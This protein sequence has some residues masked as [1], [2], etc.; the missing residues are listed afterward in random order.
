MRTR[1]PPCPVEK[2]WV[3]KHK[4]D[5]A[6]RLHYEREAMLAAA[7]PEEC[8][9]VE[10]VNGVCND[11]SVESEFKGDL[12]RARNGKKQ[13]KRKRSPKPKNV[14][15]KLDSI[16]TGLLADHVW[17]D[18]PLY[19]HAENVYRK[20]IVDCQSQ[21][22]PE[23]AVTAEQSP[24]VARSKAV[25]D[26]P[27]PRMLSAA[28]P[29]FHGSLSAC[30]HVVQDVWVNK[31]DFDKAEEVFVE[32]SQFFVPPNVLTIPSAWSNAGN[33][34]LRTPDEG[35]ATALPTPATPSL[36]PETV[37]DSAA[38][39]VTSLPGSVH[40]T[41]NGKPQI[42][43]LQA[44][45][46]EV[47]LEKPLYDDAEKSFYENMFDGHPSG[48]V[49]QQQRGCPEALKN[50]HEDRKNHSVGKQTA[51]KQ[52]EIATDSL[53]PSD[54]EQPLPTRFFLHEDSETVWLNKPTY[55]SAES[56]Y[57]AAE[58]LKM[59]RTG[60]STGMQESAV[61]KP[62]QP[63]AYASSV[64][65]PETKKMAVDYFLHEKIW[66]E[67]YKYDDAE[68]RYY[69]QM[70]GPVSSSSHQQ[71]APTEDCITVLENGA[72]TILRD[73]ARARENI[74]K[75]L[76]GKTVRSKEAPSAR[77]KRQSGRSTSASTTSS[78]PAGDQNELLSRISHLEVENQNLRSVVADLQMAIFKLE[79]RLNALEK[80]STS[81][82]PSPV[83]PTQKV[84]PF[85]VPSKKVELPSAS[86][87]KKAEP[88][89]AEED[90]DDDID[91]F[92][93][94]DEEED[95]EA[96]KVREERLR[97]YAEKKA[98]KPGLIAKSS[99]LLDVKPW[100]DETDMAKME[101]CVR[102]IHMDGLVWGASKLVP[103][104]YGIKKLQIQCVVEDDKVGTDILEEEITKFE[105]Y[106]QSVDIAA[107]NKI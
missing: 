102:S 46:S 20:K 31:F 62:S 79:S 92:G 93:S 6:E 75:S 1:K 26:V 58:A 91:L 43:S 56:R 53:L 85:S 32:K 12:K 50:H 76:A 5:E 77:H 44:L 39:F 19:D 82:Q 24:L 42:S 18:K 3:D 87:A 100:D 9:E 55:D 16:L 27:K 23:A 49:R 21:E 104:G 86:P 69:E 66:F 68:R 45:M 101:E 25:Q 60:E 94:D 61:V 8:Q 15:S 7:A 41:V 64:P 84:E 71:C 48:K 13:R 103:V 83:P 4:Y 2:V 89:A 57:Y 95:Q 107:F 99:I 97:Q 37:A 14:T 54:A 38:S 72:S 34:G 35:Y 11:D 40:Q 30:H 70:N 81:H 78:G 47:W 10:A 29:C 17:F 80:S 22:A 63:A 105:D 96:A 59:S 88:A 90:D 51:I 28:M 36:A 73:I 67:K 52:V 106:V 65:A 33:V 98:K 74:Q